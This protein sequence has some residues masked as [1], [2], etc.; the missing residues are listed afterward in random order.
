[1]GGQSYPNDFPYWGNFGHPPL[2]IFCS[3]YEFLGVLETTQDAF[4]EAHGK[5]IIL[6]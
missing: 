3:L 5:E 2:W 6:E 1:M 4:G